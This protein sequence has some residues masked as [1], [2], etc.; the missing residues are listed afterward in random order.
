MTGHVWRHFA[1]EFSHIVA[2]LLG[3]AT[4]ESPSTSHEGRGG[5]HHTTPSPML[6]DTDD[7]DM[8]LWPPAPLTAHP[9]SSSDPGPSGKGVDGPT[10]VLL[11]PPLPDTDDEDPSTR[12]QEMDA[13]GAAAVHAGS[14]RNIPDVDM[15]TGAAEIWQDGGTGRSLP[16]GDGDGGEGSGGAP[17]RRRRSSGE[18]DVG[19][20][21]DGST[22][23]VGTIGAL[24]GVSGLSAKTRSS[25]SG[26]THVDGSPD[27]GP[28]PP[29]PPL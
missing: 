1:P 14:A 9:T 3:P 11:P 27:E 17:E 8:P 6:A 12:V 28:V 13:G 26:G 7:D 4:P 18:A 20:P 15:T 10:H 22:A 5:D 24:A 29:D 21:G 25:S 19:A 2:G 23:S 16:L